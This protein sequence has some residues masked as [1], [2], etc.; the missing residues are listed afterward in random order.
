MRAAPKTRKPAAVNGE[1]NR[2]VQALVGP[3]TARYT[4]P[5]SPATTLSIY[6]GRMLIATLSMYGATAYVSDAAGRLRGPF[7]SKLA[8][9]EYVATLAPAL[10]SHPNQ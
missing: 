2:E 6:D 7:G 8:A 5:E 9:L 4:K 3:E 1:L 10:T